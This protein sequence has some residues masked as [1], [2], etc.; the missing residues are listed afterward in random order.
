MPEHARDD[1]I[2]TVFGTRTP[3]APPPDP[4]APPNRQPDPA[5]QWAYEPD[6]AR[7]LAD[8]FFDAP[9]HW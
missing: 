7:E 3:T 4:A 9:N 8:A 1:M 5:Q 2:A 6:H